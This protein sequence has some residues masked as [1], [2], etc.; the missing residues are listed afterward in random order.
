M[1]TGDKVETA[2]SIAFS[3]RLFT[4]DM[5]LVEVGKRAEQRGGLGLRGLN[6]RRAH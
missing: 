5:A 2:I 4:E 1:L 6:K 3:C